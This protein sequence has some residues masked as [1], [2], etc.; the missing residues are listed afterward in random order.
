MGKQNTRDAG[1]QKV[2]ADH[3]QNVSAPDIQNTA[4]CR[5]Q[6]AGGEHIQALK[7]V[8]GNH[9]A[10]VLSPMRNGVDV[11]GWLEVLFTVI[12]KETVDGCN[13]LR[14]YK[15]A[16]MGAYV[17]SDTSNSLDCMRE[18]YQDKL[19]AAGVICEEGEA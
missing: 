3:V 11:L 19:E 18:D 6:N 5:I 7:A 10:D 12:K 2:D 8:F 14:I 16:E 13:I 17:A 9:P 15:L 1:I 4:E